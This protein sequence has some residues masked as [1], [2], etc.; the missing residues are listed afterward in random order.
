VAPPTDPIDQRFMAAALALARRG[1]GVV[2]P[3]PAVGC[4][5]VDG[6]GDVVGRGWT[7]PGGRPHAETEALARAG[8]RARGATAYVSLEPCAHTGHTAPCAEA[9]IKAGIGR[10]VV[11]CEDPDSRV[12]GKGI[13]MLKQAGIDVRVGVMRH[14]AERLNAG[15]IG[16][17]SRGRPAVL[18]KVASTLD[19]RIAT[20]RGESKWITGELARSWGHALR[21]SHDALITGGATIRAD[22]P[23]LTCRLP[24]LESRSP[25]RVVMDSRLSLPLTARIVATARRQP[26]WLLTCEGVDE[27][28]R[29][30]F[31]DC[32]LEVIEV[33]PDDGGRPDVAA[34][35]RELAA[36][37]ITRVMVEGGANLNATFFRSR[38]VDRVAW[39]RAPDV[40]GGEGLTAVQPFGVDY[41]RDMASFTRIRTIVSGRDALEIYERA[42]EGEGSGTEG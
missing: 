20:H 1:L 37:G 21:A 19:G 31:A 24:G 33:P 17:V 14:D 4:V 30:A 34:S 9:L 40:I 25:V 10:V 11:A 8:A 32:G 7:Q 36:R 23:D 2:W 12:A 3:N 5:I 16:R 6:A 29:A 27:D 42:G 18:L 13:E 22:D 26:T 35:L 28:R 15:F 38:L 39:F 41:L